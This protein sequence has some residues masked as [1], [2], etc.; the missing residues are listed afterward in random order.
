[1]VRCVLSGATY[2]EQTVCQ[3]FAS[4]VLIT[5]QTVEVNG[6]SVPIAVVHSGLVANGVV[7]AFGVRSRCKKK[8]FFYFSC[9]VPF[10]GASV[11]VA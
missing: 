9:V 5:A 2:P 6:L 7:S 3:A 10:F 1:M 8:F 4:V 11:A